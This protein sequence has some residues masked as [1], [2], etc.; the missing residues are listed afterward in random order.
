MNLKELQTVLLSHPYP[1]KSKIGL[2]SEPRTINGL[3][4]NM[5]QSFLVA[6]PLT[7]WMG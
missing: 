6:A 5:G 3:P 7:F 1:E 4:L 2:H